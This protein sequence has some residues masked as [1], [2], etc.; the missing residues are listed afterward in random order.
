MLQLLQPSHSSRSHSPPSQSPQLSQPSRSSPVH[1]RA[2]LFDHRLSVRVLK[3]IPRASRHLV[4]TKLAHILD[5]IV[6]WN[7]EETWSHLFKFSS[8]CLAQ[9]KRGGQQCS[10]ASAV[11]RQLQEETNPPMPPRGTSRQPHGDPLKNLRSRVSFKLEGGDFKGAVHVACSE[12]SMADINAVETLG[13]L[14]EKHPPM[15][16]NS[17]FPPL[18]EGTA[19]TQI[20]ISEEDVCHAIRPFPRGSAGGPDGIRPHHLSDL[21]SASAER[22]GRELLSALTSFRNL[23]VS[24]L[25]PPFAQRIFF[26]ATLISLRKKDGGV[27]PIAVP[28]GS[29]SSSPRCKVCQHSCNPH[30]RTRFGAIAT[31]LWSPTG[32]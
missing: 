22:G 1:H 10:L 6:A 30:C 2:A 3:R 18:V 17:R 24:G 16:P 32:V 4:A 25:T 9:P 23:V 12:N 14:K 28:G 5:D 27:R 21:T 31:R 26:G 8:R 11:N 13:A 7:T 20:F 29:D 19:S 15:H